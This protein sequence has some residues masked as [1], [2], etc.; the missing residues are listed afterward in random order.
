[1]STSARSRMAALVLMPAVLCV[2]PSARADATD[3]FNV[4]DGCRRRRPKAGKARASISL[5]LMPSVLV[6]RHF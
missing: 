3:E 5:A 4:S 6:P 2:H 1:M